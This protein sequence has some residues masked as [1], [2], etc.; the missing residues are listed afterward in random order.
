MFRLDDL[1]AVCD[2][3]QKLTSVSGYREICQRQL[4]SKNCCRPWSLPNYIALLAKKE[5]CFDINVS[6]KALVNVS[7]AYQM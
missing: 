5:N 2:L 3:E 1:L 6:K 4:S 7:K